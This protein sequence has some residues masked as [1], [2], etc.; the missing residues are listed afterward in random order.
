MLPCFMMVSL[1]GWRQIYYSNA[2]EIHQHFLTGA[3]TQMIQK[4][5][6]QIPLQ[7]EQY[8]QKQ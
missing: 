2:K 5:Y 1:G 6:S 3:S 8:V 4:L 7:I